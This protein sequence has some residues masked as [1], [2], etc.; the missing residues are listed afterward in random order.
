MVGQAIASREDRRAH[1]GSNDMTRARAC[2]RRR[3]RTAEE[4]FATLT[5]RTGELRKVERQPSGQVIRNLNNCQDCL[6]CSWQDIF[7]HCTG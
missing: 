7:D 3:Q 6:W 2:V 1:G 4:F 5:L